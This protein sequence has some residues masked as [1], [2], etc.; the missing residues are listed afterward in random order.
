MTTE[1]N[2]AD[3]SILTRNEVQSTLSSENNAK[4]KQCQECYLMLKN[5]N[6]DNNGCLWKVYMERGQDE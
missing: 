4:C 6:D 3:L 5:N 1:N 2:E